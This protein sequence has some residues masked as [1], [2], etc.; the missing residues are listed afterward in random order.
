MTQNLN[1]QSQSQSNQ[2]QPKPPS[3]KWLKLALV[4]AA[5]VLIPRRSSNLSLSF[6]ESQ[7]PPKKQSKRQ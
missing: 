2:A 4:G 5:L 6:N 3:K 1:N 7:K